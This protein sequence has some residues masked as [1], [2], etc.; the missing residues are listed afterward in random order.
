[1]GLN[2]NT[3]G[4][5]LPKIREALVVPHMIRGNGPFP[6]NLRPT[7]RISSA[8]ICPGEKFCR[9]ETFTPSETSG[10]VGV[11][12]YPWL[13]RQ[14]LAPFLAVVR[15]KGLP[16]LCT[17]RFCEANPNKVGLIFPRGTRMQTP[18]PPRDSTSG[19]PETI[20]RQ[21]T[22]LWL[23]WEG[24]SGRERGQQRLLFEGSLFFISQILNILKPDMICYSSLC[25]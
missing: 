4:S 5:L 18:C 17:S 6:G 22:E 23:R 20:L 21:R 16:L 13:I 11:W 7:K 12:G 15:G 19:Q 2:S 25:V 10:Q 3:R 14:E 9:K 1:M 8:D 24:G